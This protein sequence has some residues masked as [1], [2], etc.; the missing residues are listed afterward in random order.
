MSKA[1]R[2]LTGEDVR[3]VTSE[4]MRSHSQRRGSVDED[5]KIK[6]L[7][8][9][10]HLKECDVNK[11]IRKYDRTGLI[12][13]VS[14]IEAQYGD[15]TG[16]DYKEAMDTIC[17]VQQKFEQLPSKIR[18]RFANDPAEYLKF[19]NDANNRDEAIKLGLI[20]ASW[21]PETDGLGEHI[22]NDGERKKI[23]EKVE[24]PAK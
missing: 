9:Q 3:V 4:N 5:G 1:Y 8:E 2:I 22:K 23:E 12:S 13:H 16:V 11:I 24:E 14:K 21:T 17:D 6:Y 18:K 7:T 20:D 10:H 19:F 15:M